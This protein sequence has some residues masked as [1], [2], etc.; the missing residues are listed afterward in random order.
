MTQTSADVI[1]NDAVCLQA[2]AV[3]GDPR[4]GL[5]VPAAEEFK[6]IPREQGLAFDTNA[7]R[8]PPFLQTFEGYWI[9][10]SLPFSGKLNRNLQMW[11]RH[12]SG[13]SE[14]PIE[15]LVTI[16]DIPPPVILSAFEKPPVPSSSLTWSLEFIVTP[17]SIRSEWFYLDFTVDAAADGYTQ[18]SGRIF[19]ESGQL[20]ALSRQCMVYF[21]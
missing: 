13:M 9:A 16:C 18:Q 20:C 12:R 1:S 21:G 2:M 17:E 15:K 5:R 14:L 8:L 6:P 7:K 19:D 4:D 10:G 3:F 11:V